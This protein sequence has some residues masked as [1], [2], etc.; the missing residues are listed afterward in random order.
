MKRVA[1]FLAVVLATSA[2]TPRATGGAAPVPQTEAVLHLAT[3]VQAPALVLL[4]DVEMSAILG[5]GIDWDE[6]YCSGISS[7]FADTS[8]RVGVYKLCMWVRK[9]L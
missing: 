7:V 9:A 5:A 1:V 2:G 3:P 4:S 6:I 8:T